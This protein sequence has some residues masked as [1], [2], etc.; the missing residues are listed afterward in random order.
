[1]PR[2]S[3]GRPKRYA[4]YDKLVGELP[5]LMTKRPRYLN[6]IGV[7]RGARGET[8]WIKVM[9]PL[10]GTYKGKHFEP[11][12]SVEI[13][14]GHL[15]SWS[16]AQLE[17]KRDELQGRA[18]HGEPIH[19]A[20]AISFVDF[21]GSWI[22]RNAN[23]L[24]GI[25]V[26]RIH[27]AKHLVPEFGGSPVDQ[28]TAEEIDRWIAKRLRVA[29]PSTVRRELGTLSTIL[30]DAVR[31]GHIQ[32][33]PCFDTHPIRGIVGR[34]R[35]LDAGEIVRLIDAASQSAD[36]LPEFILWC[37]HS[38]M[39][40]SEV[41]NLCWADIRE[42]QQDR[43]L[44]MVRSGKTDQIR[45]VH[46][47]DTMREILNRQRDR[48]IE[49]DDRI[50]PVSPMTLRRRWEKARSAAGL[51]DVTIHDLRRTHSTHAVAAGVDLRTLAGRLGHTDLE[52]LQRHYAALVNDTALEAAEKIGARIDHLTA[53]SATRVVI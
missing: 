12:G 43:P 21:A 2:Q 24:R 42:I 22:E 31:T 1:M 53:K 16:W 35:F 14:L 19:Q 26:A 9:L 3:R 6:G 47:T 18:D 51:D 48:Q 50:F 36:W 13:K 49:G 5:P 11:G 46:C 33:N 40:K 28:L 39:R 20:P 45:S 44:A 30:S 32:A 29:K 17:A 7:F 10:G 37:V 25:D 8:A 34:Q 15:N 41:I 38:G 4:A 27:I 23:R 52:M